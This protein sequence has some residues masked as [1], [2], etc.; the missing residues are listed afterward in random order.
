MI[1][2]HRNLL[3]FALTTT[4]LTGCSTK[5]SLQK[6]ETKE[7]A[8]SKD[9]NADI[10]SVLDKRIRPYREKMSGDMSIVLAESVH[11]LEKATPESRLGNMVSDACMLQC[12]QR[13]QPADGKAPDFLVLNN[14][15]LRKGLPKGNITKGDIFEL[16]P[17]ENELVVL[18]LNGESVKK[19]FNFIASKDGAPVSGTRFQI[20]DK[21]AIN[22]TIQGAPFDSSKT[23]KVV[24][25]D[26]LANGGDQFSMFSEAT[27]RESTG[28]KVRDAIIQYLY[29]QGKTEQKI[30]V[31][32]DGRISYVK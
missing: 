7:Y 28:L 31:E 26:Y 30:S 29:I 32:P 23:Y 19:I 3:L 14:G 4:L 17:F 8:F 1:L 5:V 13:Y 25:S 21:H 9:G 11:S 24:T 6:T 16:M 12:T 10:D 22:I 15:G 18:T 2:V 20:Q 27:L